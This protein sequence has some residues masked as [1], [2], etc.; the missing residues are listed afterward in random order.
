MLLY[1]RMEAS[2][3]AVGVSFGSPSSLLLAPYPNDMNDDKVV[4]A[5]AVAVVLF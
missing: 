5:A 1:N 3:L 2:S 4:A